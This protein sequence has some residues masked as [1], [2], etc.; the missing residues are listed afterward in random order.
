M[1]LQNIILSLMC[2]ILIYRNYI[3]CFLSFEHTNIFLVINQKECIFKQSLLCTR[4]TFKF[5]LDHLDF[6]C[7][8][9]VI[10]LT[11]QFT[12]HTDIMVININLLLGSESIPRPM[13][14]QTNKIFPRDLIKYMLMLVFKIFITNMN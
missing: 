1:L 11:Q 13:K 12:D 5:K 4:V 8:S 14:K 9:F 3:F 2:C 6:N 10:M 7:K